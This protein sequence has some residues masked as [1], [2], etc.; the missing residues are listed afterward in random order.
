MAMRI[1]YEELKREVGRNFSDEDQFECVRF[2]IMLKK[3]KR[4]IAFGRKKSA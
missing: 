2:A 3:K 1:F 4:R